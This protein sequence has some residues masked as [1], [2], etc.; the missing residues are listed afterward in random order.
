MEDGSVQGLA[1][2]MTYTRQAMFQPAK[3]KG[4]D[5]DIID[6]VDIFSLLFG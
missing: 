3:L 1:V 4:N 6:A 2:I 5:V